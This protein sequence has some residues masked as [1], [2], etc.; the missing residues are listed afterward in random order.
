MESGGQEGVGKVGAG[1]VL[2]GKEGRVFCHNNVP[3]SVPPL[4]SFPP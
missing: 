1:K 3:F 2:M 4:F